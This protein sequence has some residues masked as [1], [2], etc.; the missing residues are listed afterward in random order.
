PG[1][2]SLVPSSQ[3]EQVARDFII[4]EKPD[5]VVVM[6][7]ATCL[8]RNLNLVFQVL[9]VTNKVVVCINMIDEAE[10]KGIL[11]DTSVISHELRVPVVATA[12]R[13][14]RGLLELKEQIAL[15]ATKQ[16]SNR[17]LKKDNATILNPYNLSNCSNEKLPVSCINCLKVTDKAFYLEDDNL[18]KK[19]F[20]KA[21]HIINKAVTIKKQCYLAKNNPLEDGSVFDKRLD[22]LLTSR[23]TGIPLMFMLL[24]GIFWLTLVGA[25]YPSEALGVFLFWLQD[26]LGD[27]IIQLGTPNWL[28]GI[29]VLGIFRTLAWVVSVMLPPMA[30]FFPLF[31]FFEDLGYLPRIAFTLDHYFKKAGTQG[32]QALTMSMGFGCNA[33]GIIAARI[34]DSPRERLIAII[35]NNFV[36]CNGRFPTL[37]ILASIFL[38][39]LSTPFGSLAAPIAVTLLVAF[40]VFV[41]LTVSRIL[42]S[43]LLKGVPSTFTLELPPYRR[44][45]IG[46]IVVRSILDRTIFVLGR[47]IV[48]AAPAGA[49]IWV[50]ANVQIGSE[51]LLALLANLL[52][53]LGS[54][55]GLDGYILT[56]FLAGFPANEIVLPIL[57]MGYIGEGTM[58][59]PES[60]GEIKQL[61]IDNGWNLLTAINMMLF[62]LLHFPCGTTLLTINKETGNLKWG[63]YTVIITTSAA[64]LVCFLTTSVFRLMS[65]VF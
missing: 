40:G 43:T 32:K 25:N 42:S 9:D 65:L 48:V 50:L 33:A 59:S 58:V 52:H 36:P 22:Y 24:C 19:N 30:I 23:K 11:I 21:E 55:I 3:D 49:V 61:F 47:A 57:I 12:A 31:T 35:T 14:G 37:I 5:V 60:L 15:I 28:Y 1:T 6:T 26:I 56:A 20:Q 8:E 27:L 13:E 39:G 2:Y 54:V 34:I 41:T 46:R 51:S 44:P 45:Q 62:S 53:P 18:V 38:G 64:F 17:L 63:A 29:V 4:T 16:I 7:D 10:K